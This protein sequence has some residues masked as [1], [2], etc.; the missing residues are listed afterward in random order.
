MNTQYTFILKKVGKIHTELIQNISC[1]LKS[2][3]LGKNLSE[4]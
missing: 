1:E 4:I 3:R 2:V